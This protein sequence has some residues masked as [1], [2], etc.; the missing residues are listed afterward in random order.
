MFLQYEE[1]KRDPI[2]QLG[3]AQG[4]GGYEMEVPNSA[5]FRL[6]VVG[7]WK[8]YLAP[9]TCECLDRLAGVEFEGIGRRLS[10]KN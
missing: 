4:P 7:E 9:E 2:V 8:N 3:E 5:F 10:G 6:G 1:L